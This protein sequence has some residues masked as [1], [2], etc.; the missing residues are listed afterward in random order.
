MKICVIGAGATG[1]GLA[2]Y[3]A[4]KGIDITL[5]TRSAEK[6]EAINQNGITAT[7]AFN[8]NY[9]VPTTTDLSEAVTGAEIIILMTIANAHREVAERLKPFL[10]EGQKVI[11]FNSNWGAFQFTQVL[12]EDIETKNLIIAE[13]SAQLFI[14]SLNGPNEVHTNYKKQVYFSATDPARTDE[15]LNIT[16][17]IFPQ[18]AKASSIIETTMSSTNPVI[19]VP[20]TLLNLVRVEKAQHFMFYGEGVSHTSVKMILDID[21]ERLAIAKALGC[22]ISDVLS[23]IN[24]F[25][26]IK[27]PNLYDALTINDDYL[28][29][30]GPKT[31][32]HRFL[33]E[34]VPYGIAPIAKIGRLFGVPT[35][36][37]DA[38]L[39]ILEH[40][41]GSEITAEGVNFRKEDFASVQ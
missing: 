11:I 17:D 16:R 3:L 22:E 14:G 28:R 19:H 26:E 1:Q 33:T 37:T 9:R 39:S 12:G 34:D 4:D 20:I 15:V 7:G 30:V 31:L 27:H 18:F 5:N 2:V 36:H 13:T 25:W 35:P 21:K 23:A 32:N 24:S 40:L 38:L 41:L 29:A 10:S 8:A 6:A